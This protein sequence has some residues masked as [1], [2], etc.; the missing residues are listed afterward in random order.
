MKGRYDNA[1]TPADLI[2][3]SDRPAP[4][5]SWIAFHLRS[6]PSSDSTARPKS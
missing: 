1:D 2:E 3:V 6:Q 4:Y 5:R